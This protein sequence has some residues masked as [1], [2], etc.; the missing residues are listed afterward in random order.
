MSTPRDRL[1]VYVQFDIERYLSYGWK[2]SLIRDMIYRRHAYRITHSCIAALQ[3]NNACP[4]KCEDHCWILRV[5]RPQ[6]RQDW[7]EE[8]RKKTAPFTP[9][10]RYKG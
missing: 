10:S 4:R 5:A 3:N 8:L 1:P 2:Q 6:P 7:L 9:V